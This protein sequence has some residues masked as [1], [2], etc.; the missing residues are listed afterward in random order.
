[1][2]KNLLRNSVLL[3]AVLFASSV[4]AQDWVNMMQDP[5]ANFYDVQNAFNQYNAKAERQL[6]KEKRKLRKSKGENLSEE[7]IEVPGLEQYKRWEWFMAPRVSATGQRPAPE[8]TWNAMVEYRKGIQT[9]GTGGAGTWTFIGPS[10]TGGL[11]GAGRLNRIVVNPTTNS[12]IYAC[13]PAGGLWTSTN[14]GTSWTTNTDQLPSVIGCSDLAFDPTNSQIM[15][16]AT[17]DGEAGDNN[18]VGLLKSIDGGTTWKPT[19]LSFN[20]SQYRLMSRVI[21]DPTNGNN[22][23]VATSAG[24]Y[25]STNAGTSFTLVQA[26][27]FKSMELKPG[28]PST[29]YACGVEFFYSTNSGTTWAK[30]TGFPAATTLC[31]MTMGVSANSPTTVYVNVGKAAPTYGIDGFYKSTTSGVSFTKASTPPVGSDNQQWYDLPVG[32][33]PTNAQ[34][35]MI[36]GQ[37]TFLKSTNGGTSWTT[38]AS[39]THVDYHGIT[40]DPNGTTAYIASDG[41]AYKTT[42][43]GTS[44]ANINNNLA[45]SEMYG[46]GQSKTN[47][48]LL[49]QG[50]QDNGTNLYTGSWSS[51]MGGDGMLAFISWGSDQN[52]WGSQYNGSLNRSTNGG[53][54]WGACGAVGGEACPWVT[55]WNE[56]PTTANTIYVGCANVWKSTNGGST[57]TKPGSV[58]GTSTVQIT[59]IATSPASSQVMWTGKGGT[60]YKTTNGGT[61]WTAVTTIPPGSISDIICHP[62]DVN[63]AWV[64]MSGFSAKNKVFMTTDQGATWTNLSASI[65]NISVNCMAIDKN[66]NDAVYIGTDVG[67]F[68]KDATMTVWQPFSNGLPNVTVSQIE[69]F[70]TGSKI[71]AS[72]YGRGMWESGLY[73][74]GAYLPDANFGASNF[75]GCPGLGVQFTDYSAGQPTSWSWSFPGGSPSTSTAQNPFVVYNTPG[76]YSVT[77]TATNATGP[78]TQTFNNMI[79]ISPSQAAPTAT[80]KTICGPVSVTLTATPSA[81]GSVHWWNAPSGGTLLGTGNTLTSTLWGTQTIYVDESFPAGNIDIVGP[82]DKTLGGGASFTASDIRGLYFDVL[83]AVTINSV[84][85]YA[86][87]AGIRTIEIIDANGNLVTDTT[88]NIPASATTPATVTINRTV[89][90]GTNYFIKFR[91]NVDCW[92]N[93]D[94]AAYPYTDGGSNSIVITNSNAGSPGYYYFFYDWQFTNIVCNTGRTPVV[95]TDTCSLTGVNDLF[96]NNQLDIFPNPNNGQFSVSFH[97]E[98]NDNY[99]VKVTN[100]I[101]QTVYEEKLDNFSGNYSNKIDITSFNKG[102]Y[103]LS[104]SNSK[105]ETVKKVLVY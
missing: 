2:K 35:I 91:G 50:W 44:W 60:L 37:I 93:S 99:T 70:Y 92:R 24:V 7:E 30:A 97:T 40:Y 61:S 95:I 1:M 68:F 74:A 17:G 8:A 88:L 100:T 27:S 63:K 12:T 78:D 86:T 81:P 54:S 51:A 59:A 56:D 6:E 62:T 18:S 52:M 39:S 94:G 66:G 19:G 47:A 31:R 29:I 53:A 105:N 67:C 65:P 22:I 36:G 26:G 79:T 9:Q 11:S 10:A 75:I 41:G 80:G 76:T 34:E 101:G 21:V 103:M 73:A 82:P 23:Y 38:I 69:I 58:A 33:S 4:F 55:E 32:V 87:T 89:Y 3:V 5:N 42:N 43:G 98:K 64:S 71:R 72:T 85:V 48:S 15:Y 45:I 57:F 83:K 46:F 77:L 90:P 14:G 96:V 102:V 49:I 84:K 104:V 20:A 16:L 25:K 28:T 13:S